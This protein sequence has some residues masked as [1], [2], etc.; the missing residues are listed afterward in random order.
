MMGTQKRV[1]RQFRHCANITECTYTNLDGV[2]YYTPRLDGQPTVLV[3][4]PV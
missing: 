2:A 3:Y 4:K 1:I